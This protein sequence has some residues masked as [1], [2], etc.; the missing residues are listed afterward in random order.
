MACYNIV[1][2]DRVEKELR[3]LS[4]QV[5]ERIA[6]AIDGLA[7]DPTPLASRRMVGVD[8]YRLRVGD[9]RI[10]YTVEH[11]IVTVYVVRVGHRREIYR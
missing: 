10:I 5:V 3:K 9:Y 6:K 4:K 11:K 8:G 7:S 1:I 2:E